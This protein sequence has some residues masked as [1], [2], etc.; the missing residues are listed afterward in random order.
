MKKMLIHVYFFGWVATE[1]AELAIELLARLTI[2]NVT[3]DLPLSYLYGLLN[4]SFW[5]FTKSPREPSSPIVGA[6][7]RSARRLAQNRLLLLPEMGIH[8]DTGCQK[9][10]SMDTNEVRSN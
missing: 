8:H 6:R 1:R 10:P 2:S 7:G 5:L 4:R 9:T 3:I